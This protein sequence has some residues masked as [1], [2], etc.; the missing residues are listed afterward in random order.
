MKLTGDNNDVSDVTPFTM[1]LFFF[2]FL[3]TNEWAS[4]PSKHD[5]QHSLPT[6]TCIFEI[7][8]HSAGRRP[9]TAEPDGHATFSQPVS[10]E[11][12]VTKNKIS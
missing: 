9:R 1:L 12:K 8:P 4:G 10:S 7:K 3:T 2:F 11:S 6:D 5:V